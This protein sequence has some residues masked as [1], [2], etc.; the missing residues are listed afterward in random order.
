[1]AAGTFSWLFVNWISASGLFFDMAVFDGMR[2][3]EILAIR[4]GNVR[5]DSVLI[6]QAS[7]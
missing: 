3:G 7:L 2:P 6:D 1:M 4:L 5:E